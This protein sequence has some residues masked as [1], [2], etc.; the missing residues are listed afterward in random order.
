MY[1]N[2]YDDAVQIINNIKHNNLP[3][4]IGNNGR[5]GT[6]FLYFKNEQEINYKIIFEYKNIYSDSP[7]NIAKIAICRGEPLKGQQMLKGFGIHNNNTKLTLLISTYLC[8]EDCTFALYNNN[9]LY[10]N[11]YVSL[12]KEIPLKTY[13]KYQR[14]F[15][16]CPPYDTSSPLSS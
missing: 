15:R 6:S 10:H 12:N 13:L 11:N 5:Y 14:I 1:F 7:N 2:D 16:D 4:S 8:M 9:S 3:Y